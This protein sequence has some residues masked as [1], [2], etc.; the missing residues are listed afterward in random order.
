MTL[1]NY[2]AGKGWRVTVVTIVGKDSD[3][4]ILDDRINHIAL[5]L[6]VPSSTILHSVYHNL[7]RV[8]A[9]RAVLRSE[10]PD[11]AIAMMV[12][13]NAL[14]ALAGT[15]LG[16]KLF[17][18]ERNYPPAMQIGPVWEKIRRWTY[19]KLSMLVAQTTKESD[20]FRK[21]APRVSPDA[22]LE[23]S[24]CDRTLLAV[25]RL[26]EQKGFDRLIAA[27]ASISR[28]YPRW[29]LIILGEGH[30]RGALE[31]QA[32]ALEVSE[33]VHMPGLVGNVG[34]W[35]ESADI[36]VLTSRYEGFP[37]TLLEALAYG[38]PAVAV[39]CDVGPR[40]IL[41]HTVDGLLVRQDDPEALVSALEQLMCDSEMRRR[42]R[43]RAP[44][45][46]KRYSV[47]Q[48]ATMWEDLF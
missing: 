44:E 7:V 8:R 14:L 31:M 1:A 9:L 13:A 3:F 24:G 47:A 16:I 22:E 10:K 4:Y 37:N 21:Q 27:F 32:L 18:S 5:D 19:P 11:V 35:F 26:V 29:D 25:G 48:I 39:D 33:R 12:T 23:M 40:D 15:G 43:R 2:W 28:K 6:V 17:G 41:S 36:Y 30:L 38:L 34:D 20:W 45:V 42:F 46:L